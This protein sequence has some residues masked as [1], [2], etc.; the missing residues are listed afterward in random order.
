MIVGTTDKDIAFHPFGVAL[1]CNEKKEA[2]KFIF[3][4][5]KDSVK[6]IHPYDYEPTALVADGSDAITNGFTS[7]F[8]YL[9]FRV[10]CW[11]HMKKAYEDHESYVALDA[12]HKENIKQDI[13]VLQLSVSTDIFNSTY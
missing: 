10:M 1:C 13:Y 9:L 5:I 6:E 2:F 4:S 3:Q 7:V 12:P 11:F 8:K